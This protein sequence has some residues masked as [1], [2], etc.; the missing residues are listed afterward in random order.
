MYKGVDNKMFV[1]IP[2]ERKKF[3]P[4]TFPEVQEGRYIISNYGDIIDLKTGLE[5]KLNINKKK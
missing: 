1:V 3:K 2:V 5:K 4:L